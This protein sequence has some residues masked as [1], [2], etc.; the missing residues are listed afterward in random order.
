ML[1]R[2]YERW[3]VNATRLMAW[4]L[5]FAGFAA[6]PF[7]SWVRGGGYAEPAFQSA[8]DIPLWLMILISPALLIVISTHLL[9]FPFDAIGIDLPSLVEFPLMMAGGLLLVTLCYIGLAASGEPW[10]ARGEVKR[11]EE[12][13]VASERQREREAA[14]RAKTPAQKQA[15]HEAWMA[16][17]REAFLS[18]RPTNWRLVALQLAGLGLFTVLLTVTAW[19]AA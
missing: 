18:P 1:E 17:R 7:N 5:I 6:L 16:E 9:V 8:A 15:E 14:E 2:W 13:R 4:S 11:A 10:T 3:F 19:I 12:K